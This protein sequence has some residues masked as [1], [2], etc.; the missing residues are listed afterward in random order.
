MN[1]PETYFEDEVVAGYF[2]DARMKC[3]WAATLEVLQVIDKICK[4]YNIPYFAEWGTL[5]GTVR[6]GGFIPWDDDM[7]ICMKRPDY[8]RFL[9]V[10]DREL[11]KG[12]DYLN[13]HNQ[14]DYWDVMTRVVNSSEI[15]YKPEFLDKYHNMPYVVGVDIFPLDYLAR[16]KKLVQTQ[17]DLVEYVKSVADVNGTQHMEPEELEQHLLRIEE[18]C[19]QKIDRQKSIK[20]QLY[21][22]V[23]SLY[24]IYGER[25]SD[26]IALMPLYLENGG[27]VYPKSYFQD[28]IRMPFENMTMP[29]P[30]G[31]DD[32]LK[33]KYGDYMKNV[34]KGGSHDYPY[35]EAQEEFLIEKDVNLPTY[36][37]PKDGKKSKL[38]TF[39]QDIDR[40]MDLLAQ[41]HEKV[42]MVLAVGEQE[43]AL[44]CLEKCQ[45]LAIGIGRSIEKKVGEGSET[46]TCLE[47]YCEAVFQIY[48]VLGQ[49]NALDGAAVKGMLDKL[50]HVVKI[51]FE[52]LQIKKEIVFMPYHAAHWR[53]LEPLWKEAVS[54]EEND[55]KVVPLP[56][57]Y[58]KIWSGEV[59][60]A[61]CDRDDFPEY[62]PITMFEDYDVQNNH[63]DVIV[64]QN[65][66][67]E[68]NYTVTVHT[69]YYAEAL[70]EQCEELIYIPWF[71]LD[72][73]NPED[74]RGLKSRKY[75][76]P[77]PGLVY[78][79]KVYL[80]SEGMKE[81][82]IDYLCQWA[83][84]DTKEVWEEKITAAP[85]IYDIPEEAVPRPVEWGDKKVL[86]YHI[87]GNGLMEHK[88]K[89][90]DKIR[91]SLY[92]FEKQA[93]HIQIIWLQDAMLRERL[94]KR[95]PA[96][97]REYKHL[98]NQARDKSWI[99]IV[100]AE[101][102]TKWLAMAD[103]YYGD[104]GRNAQ[105]MRERNKPVM[106]QNVDI[107]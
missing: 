86:V 54:H 64:I 8:E 68:W 34:R 100:E 18:L 35:F 19:N 11:P 57:F 6:H 41:V 4:K 76:V 16:D 52:N 77:M 37:Y 66:W 73:M 67:D 17:K 61:H 42:G 70:Q 30:I 93:E 92:V 58:K 94:E 31:Y 97:Y 87:S 74:G 69:N 63:P 7:D 78:A 55:V 36:Q 29:V 80:Q 81:S 32:I 106:L 15:N 33:K 107:S 28:S 79:D 47:K 9:K 102:G 75:F 48:E 13:Y 24:A 10:L 98:V 91:S 14:E 88:Q 26:E 65:P 90:L 101:E 45:E 50:I 105:A 12:Y 51:S 3:C 22:I 43:L 38:P 40:R 82:Y 84:E 103:A 39:R 96:T 60:E 71:K 85:R 5:L 59:G 27:C 20:D 83:G 25:E 89:M 62:V 21:K 23:C 53:M 46:V 104:A 44:Q 1:F 95:I 56:Y 2:I 99:T 49:G 72:E